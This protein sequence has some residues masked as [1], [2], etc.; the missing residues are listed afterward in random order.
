M[1]GELFLRQPEHRSVLWQQLWRQH[2]GRPVRLL[3]GSSSA[4]T[5]ATTAPRLAAVLTRPCAKTTASTAPA[6]SATAASIAAAAIPARPPAD[7]TSTIVLHTTPTNELGAD[8]RLTGPL[9]HH[10]HVGLRDRHQGGQP[11]VWLRLSDVRQ[12]QHHVVV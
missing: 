12:H 9:L 1:R 5:A 8:L 7:S 6:V 3:H 2:V 10:E 4:A 11:G